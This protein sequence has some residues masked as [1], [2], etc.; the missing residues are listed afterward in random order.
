MFTSIVPFYIKRSSASMFNISLVSQIFW[1]YLVDIMLNDKNPGG[2]L[3]YIGFIII[4]AGIYLFNK[5]NVIVIFNENNKSLF[6]SL[7]ENKNNESVQLN[8][9]NIDKY[10]NIDRKLTEY[11][12]LSLQSKAQK[13]LNKDQSI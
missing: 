9:S 10:N 4:I 3:Y 2:Y 1:S 11:R 7:L 8:N 12:K 13:Y 5:N 6:Q